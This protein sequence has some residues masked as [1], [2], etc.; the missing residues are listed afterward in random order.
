MSPFPLLF[1]PGNIG[2]MKLRNRI[3]MAPLGTNLAD[4]NGAV[5]R[6]LIDWYAERARGGA[7]LIIVENSLADVRFGRGL[8]RQL[9]IDDPRLTPG[10]N[11]LAEAV[12]ASGAKIAIQ[13]NIQ[14]AGVD[15]ELLPGVQPVGASPVSYVFDRS[16]PG[17]ALPPRM[18][19]EKRVRGLELREMENLR[20]SFIRAAGIAKSAGFDALEIHG[21]H[22]YLLAG[23]LSAF[24]NKRNDDYGGGLEGRLKYVI[25]VCRGIREVVGNEFPLLF[26]MS[27]R[28]FLPGGREVEESRAIAK[29]L[30]EVGIDGLDISA[31]ISM[32][33]EPYTWMN[34]PTAFPQ[35][36]FIADA[37]AIKKDVRIPVIGVGKIRDPWFAERVLLEG[38]ADF[39]AMGRTLIADPEWPRKAAEGREGE[40][41]RCVS[42]NRCLRILYR[43]PIRCAVNARAGLEREF[44]L[45]PAL[46]PR[47]IA[48]VGGGPAGME[49]ARTA[50]ERGHEVTLFEKGRALGGQLRLAIVPPFKKDLVGL[51]AYL[52]G[53]VKKRVNLHL[54]NEINPQELVEKRFDAVIVAT[55]CTPPALK[56]CKDGRVARAWDVLAGR[57]KLG[58]RRVVV[59]GKG[60]VACETSEFLA[61]RQKKEVT[62]IHSGPLEELGRELE[63]IFE[64]R[65]LLGRLQEWEV[66]IL[67]QTAIARIDAEGME[68]EGPAAGRLPCDHIVLEEPPVPD[69]LLLD[70][71]RGKMNVIGIGDC[72]EPSDLYRAIHD[73]FR[74][75][76]AI[77]SSPPSIPEDGK[78]F[79][80]GGEQRNP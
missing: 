73:G 70:E 31:G 3:V 17:S 58:G 35:G 63:P 65:L 71:L 54:E 13:V 56:N 18:R 21:A 46:R 78:E 41:R 77:E 49:A 4:V 36:S 42:C 16:G 34:P 19:R 7:G 8:A 68:V 44:P 15:G 27:A 23:F 72:V 59:I 28:E 24:S 55:G 61:S 12:Q 2:S 52:Q 1:Q 32:E 51:L 57:A 53:Q 10:L 47:K 39:I 22:G 11:E 60:R 30:E 45:I 62:L 20:D 64:R 43:L 74:A 37:Q 6:A 75:G 29:R 38:Q 14:G 48:V 26:R 69:R 50:A 5:T 40:I 25:E 66:K 80:P 76:Y 9:R 33:A 67:C 79:Y